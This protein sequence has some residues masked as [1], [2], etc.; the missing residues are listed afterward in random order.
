M[1]A[2][3][4]LLLIAFLFTIGH[5]TYSINALIDYLQESGYYDIIY[6]I[7]TCLGNDV[8]IEFCRQIV[9]TEHCDEVVKVYIDNNGRR[10][11]VIPPTEDNLNLEGRVIYDELK[12]DNVD[13]VK[14]QLVIII[15]SF[16]DTLIKKMTDSEIYDFINTKILKKRTIIPLSELELELIELKRERR[17]DLERL[18]KIEKVEEKEKVEKIE[19]I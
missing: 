17:E 5:S 14:R 9:E 19:N 6:Y 11:P 16:Y 1:K 15:L 8:A 13:D 7:Q 12:L 18:E 10:A 2:L 3:G 4:Y